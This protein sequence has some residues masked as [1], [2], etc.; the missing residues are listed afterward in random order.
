MKK[1]TM[2]FALTLIISALIGCQSLMMK[3]GLY[4]KGAV[5]DCILQPTT[6]IMVD[7][8][9]FGPLCQGSGTLIHNDDGYFIISAGHLVVQGFM[10]TREGYIM[11]TREQLEFRLQMF[12]GNEH[13]AEKTFTETYI[14]LVAVDHD[15]DMALFEL[16]E[17][18]EIEKM[19]KE[20]HMIGRDANIQ[21]LDRLYAAGCGLGNDPMVEH[22]FLHRK[23]I[24]R[25]H[26]KNKV[27]WTMSAP[28]VFGFSGGGIY[29]DEGKLMGVISAGSV[30]KGTFY[31]HITF[32]VPYPVIYKWFDEIGFDPA[33]GYVSTVQPDPE[34]TE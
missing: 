18:N 19:P 17:E 31:E 2:L 30:A 23:S 12:V 27:L 21:P 1:I 7:H 34:T 24:T 29:N 5:Q 14:H 20:A 32:F 9:D 4:D 25:E 16:R 28:I 13:D 6:R 8:E 33:K 22:G 3:D 26:T 15:I 11:I 10:R